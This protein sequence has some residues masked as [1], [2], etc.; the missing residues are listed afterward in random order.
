M[1]YKLNSSLKGFQKGEYEI[2]IKSGML[3]NCN[4]SANIEGT[5]Q[6]VGRDIP[7]NI[8]IKIKMKGSEN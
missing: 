3:E 4:I 2:N 5:T 7:I 8:D 6:V 1:G